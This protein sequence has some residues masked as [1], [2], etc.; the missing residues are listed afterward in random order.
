MYRE[1]GEPWG[2]G[3]QGRLSAGSGTA[4]LSSTLGT[5]YTLD[6]HLL[7][8][9]SAKV[10]EDAEELDSC[11]RRLWEKWHRE[12]F[13]IKERRIRKAQVVQSCFCMS[14]GKEK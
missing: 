2:P 6:M 9:F 11:R 8:D 5:W 4:T 1:H 10:L 12:V 14:Q 3:E 7:M 13:W